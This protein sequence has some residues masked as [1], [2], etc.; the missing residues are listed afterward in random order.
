MLPNT[1]FIVSDLLEQLA[2]NTDKE[3]GNDLADYLIQLDWRKF[4]NEVIPVPVQEPKP[5]KLPINPHSVKSVKS[6]K[7]QQKL[8]WSFSSV[9]ERMTSNHEAGSA[10][11]PRTLVGSNVHQTQVQFLA[12]ASSF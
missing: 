7:A 8:F 3:E 2:P 4:R 10:I 6:V 5:L 11:L 12:P 9:A 1:R